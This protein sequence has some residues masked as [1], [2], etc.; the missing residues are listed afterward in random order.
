M[1]LA[2][3]VVVATCPF[4]WFNG[5]IVATYAF[6]MVTCP[7]LI[8]LAWRAHPGSW[9]GVGA[10]VSLGILAGFRQSLIQSFAIPRADRGGGI[11][12]P[13]ES[14]G[15]DPGGRSGRGGGLVGPH[16][17]QPTRRILRMDPGHP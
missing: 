13:L 1:G 16:V 9:H 4:A 14:S 17:A 10:A 12:P 8:I 11:D 5:S 7:L 6:D 3:G 2:A 15:A